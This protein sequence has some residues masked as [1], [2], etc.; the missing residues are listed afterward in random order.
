MPNKTPHSVLIKQVDFLYQ[1]LP[2]ALLLSALISLFLLFF[3]RD[4]PD[5]RAVQI[6]VALML[7]LIVLRA[8]STIHYQKTKNQT[9]FQV[10]KAEAVFISGVAL[11]GIGWGILG[12]WFYPLAGDQSTH[13][14]IFMV[15]VGIAAGAIP[16]LSYRRLP[17]LLFV[18]L[19]LLPIVIGLHRTPGN[20]KTALELIS[21]IYALFIVKSGF[22][23][24]KHHEQMLLL[25]EEAVG[26]EAKLKNAREKAEAANQAKSRFLANMSHEI[27][28]PMNSIIGQTR[29]AADKDLDRKT[30][31]HLKMIQ[32]SSQNLLALINDILDFSKIEAGELKIENKPFDLYEIVLSIL[33]TV[34]VLAE[35]H[36]GLEVKDSIAPDVPRA[37]IGDKLRLRQILINLL[38]NGVKFTKKGS[39]T[40]EIERLQTADDSLLIQ[41]TVHDT[42]IGIAPD[43]QKY[44][45]EEFTQEDDSS[46]RKF[47]GTGLGLAI[48]RQLCELMGGNL[49][50]HSIPDQ[51]SSFSFT[52]P[53]MQ[54]KPSELPTVVTASTQKKP[55]QNSPLSILLVEDNEANRILARMILE[56]KNH[57]LK[58]AH[59]GLQALKLLTEHTFDIVLMDV[60]MP[61]MDGYTA[62]RA[63]RSAEQ[64]DQTPELDRQLAT[65][66]C[67]RL[68]A[69][70]TP[71]IAMTANAM[72]GDR[73]KCLAAGMDDYLAKPFHP[74][75]LASIFNNLAINSSVQMQQQADG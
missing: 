8:I 55:T 65:K 47:G 33:N 58:E 71:I 40:L 49:K 15:I 24:Q 31:F 74:E 57:R 35:E 50:V 72:S 56:E 13:I 69:S 11:S 25:K 21:I 28:T 34:K 22:V 53:F 14:F 10:E 66:L 12:W 39:V 45:F 26:R 37:V 68:R 30:Q 4:F 64:G 17:I 1:R 67:E 54:C 9:S 38:N 7:V 51:G 29:L 27:R 2:S 43:K 41:F 46:T 73:E 52:I 44:I 16:S 48:C 5:Q 70:H 20:Q 61:V 75:E 62:T 18:F 32:N 3:L 36:K 6:W 19:T 63:I 42:G 59:D 60:Q 23:F